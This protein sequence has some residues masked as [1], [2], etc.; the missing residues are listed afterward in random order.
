MFYKNVKW[1][2]KLLVFGFLCTIHSGYC[3]ETSTEYHGINDTQP[4]FVNE[5][6]WKR[7]SKEND[8]P[9]NFIN[10]S[11]C[12]IP[13][14]DPLSPEVLKFYRPEY[15]T[16]CRKEKPLIKILYNNQ[17]NRYILNINMDSAQQYSPSKDLI[18][19]K[20]AV[21]CCYEQIVRDGTGAEADNK[22]M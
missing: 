15:T 5:V 11:Q 1:M 16:G 2:P 13:Y 19:Q 10:T 17:A 18:I 21:E 7:Y 6:V 9:E 22:F 14:V 20:N 12:H 8:N 4:E 3:F